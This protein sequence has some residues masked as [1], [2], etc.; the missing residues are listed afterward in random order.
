MLRPGTR[1]GSHEIVAPLGVGG[2]GEVY[3]ATD[4]N[5]K[6]Q[7][8]I[9][10]LPASVA[11]DPE[12]LARFQ[13]EAEILAAL[14]HP[15]IA[16]I[17]GLE[18]SHGTVALVM[19]LVEGPTLADRI[20]NGPIPLD[21]ALSI[22]KQIAEALE[23]AHEQGIIHR[24]LKPANIKV[25]DDGTVKVL[26]FGLAKAL[27]PVSGK[28]ADVTASPTI[29][30]PA[31]TRM[32]V[33]LGTAPYMSPE[34]AKGRP[35]NKRSD[36]WA[37]GCVVYEMLTGKR[38][39]AGDDVADTLAAVLRGEP[40]WSALP[41]N[42]PPAVRTLLV[43]CLEKERVRRLADISVPLF[44]LSEPAVLPALNTPAA[45]PR[46]WWLRAIPAVG[47]A[48]V[49]GGLAGLA[50]WRLQASPPRPITRFA[51][52]LGDG[53]QFTTTGFRSVAMSPDGSQM[54]Y[55]ANNRLYLRS[56]SELEARPIAGTEIGQAVNPVFSPD[57][58]SLAYW[59]PIDRTLKRIDVTGGMPVTICPVG[60]APYGVN[61]GP[62]GIV[63]GE[64]QGSRG[65]LR[66]SANGGTPEQLV[67]VNADEAAGDPQMLPGGQSVLFTLAT[68]TVEANRWEWDTAHIVVQSLKST[69]RK[70][71]I[72]VGSDARYLP[73]GHIVYAVAGTLF[74][75]PFDLQRLA[76]TDGRTPVVEGV[77]R[78]GLLSGS[79][80]F[81]VSNT[82]S[83]IYIPGPVS[84]ASGDRDLALFDRQGAVER[85]KLPPGPYQHPRISPDDKQVAFGKDDGKE[86]S[87]WVYELS[88]TSAPR[89]LTFGGRNKFPIWSD[90]GQHVAF[91]SDREGDLG[92]F[93][94]RSDGTAPAERLTKADPGTSH[95]PESWWP[96]SDRFSFGIT[97]GSSTSLWTRSLKDEKVTALGVVQSAF[98]TSS[99]FSPDGR[100]IAYTAGQAENPGVFVQ[101]FPGPGS[102]YQ[103]SD[104]VDPLWS[105]DGTELFFYQYPRS[106]SSVSI[107]TQPSFT[108]GTPTPVGSAVPLPGA[109]G[110]RNYDVTGD[111]KRFIG[112][113]RHVLPGTGAHQIQV[114]L[115]WSEELKQRVPMK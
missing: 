22:A 47:V 26:D 33:I 55:V 104:A 86:A 89:Q 10:V 54:A 53:Q 18:K 80:H 61:W 92:I 12:R 16:H 15:N 74:A 113:M 100:W 41:Q 101:P 109:G 111:G 52:T 87:V 84:V 11:A 67:S 66:V 3:R 46:P 1:L 42:V 21:E 27:E 5:L 82:G 50:V 106:F 73:T 31:M 59:A 98:P 9:K 43:R 34:Q 6:R 44:L 114:V 17:H 76:V 37:F 13:R 58:R 71:L 94:Q 115:N 108:V 62:E 68:G 40:D 14:N 88:G 45:R 39:F 63:F 28:G 91:Q 35:A 48:I 64:S 112:T 85:L 83:L 97:K 107:S 99:V 4:T 8:A 78:G 24:D 57:G 90:D 56:M 38:A 95:V 51:F 79:A 70:T 23:A 75:V 77:M 30:S 32:G 60:R 7:V 20:A 65:V 49:A 110:P 103:I 2:M 81:S 69:E 102:P 93:W 105:R 19:E 25:R 72:Q 96:K 36:V 29:T